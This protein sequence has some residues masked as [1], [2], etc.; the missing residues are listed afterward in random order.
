MRRLRYW[1]QLQI[2]KR[3]VASPCVCV[4]P[5]ARML[6]WTSPG[7]SPQVHSIGGSSM[8]ASRMGGMADTSVRAIP[9][10][11]LCVIAPARRVNFISSELSVFSRSS[12]Y[13]LFDLPLWTIHP[14]IATQ[15]LLKPPNTQHPASLGHRMRSHCAPHPANLDLRRIRTLLLSSAQVRCLLS[16]HNQS[17]RGFHARYS[18]TPGISPLHVPQLHGAFIYNSLQPVESTPSSVK[19]TAAKCD[20]LPQ[21]SSASTGMVP[22]TSE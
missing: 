21:T 16:L 10:A 5:C 4:P 1:E 7:I 9:G 8:R 19:V 14:H 15:Q 20:G 2:F 13:M 18:S 6:L 22:S 17:A 11:A 12:S 3:P